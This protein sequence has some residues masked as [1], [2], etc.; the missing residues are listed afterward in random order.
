MTISSRTP[1]GQPAC[2]PV[3]DKVICLEPSGQTGDA[4]CPYCGTLLWFVSLPGEVRYYE[5]GKVSESTRE[6]IAAFVGKWFGKR[7]S[8]WWWAF[9]DSLDV[10]EL[11][12]DI[13]DEF[14]VDVSTAEAQSWSSPGDL[15]DFLLKACEE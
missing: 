15:I 8:R 13:A 11:L 6:R 4:P 7:R 12:M 14:G 10:A 2:C 9:G 5:H 3:C 1:E